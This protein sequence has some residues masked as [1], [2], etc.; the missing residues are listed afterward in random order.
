MFTKNILY[1]YELRMTIIDDFSFMF[2]VVSDEQIHNQIYFER[3]N[4]I[5]WKC[6]VE[7]RFMYEL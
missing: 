2:Y 4:L 6:D 3:R 7:C 5:K 1:Q